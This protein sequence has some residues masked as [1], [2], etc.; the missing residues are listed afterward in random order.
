MTGKRY[1]GFFGL[2]SRE[3]PTR[4]TAYGC[5][6]TEAMRWRWGGYSERLRLAIL[7]PRSIL[8]ICMLPVGELGKM[9]GK[10]CGGFGG[11][12]SRVIAH[13]GLPLRAGI[14]MGKVSRRM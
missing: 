4:G 6:P 13:H 14:S 2:R 11:P 10:R 1:G 7:M 3:M 5:R 12:P 8:Q 9:T